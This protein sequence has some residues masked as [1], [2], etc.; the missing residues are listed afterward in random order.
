MQNALT[1]LSVE[2]HVSL[3][4]IVEGVLELAARNQLDDLE[5]YLLRH[6]RSVSEKSVWNAEG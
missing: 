5:K 2:K 6:G 3:V 4:E 1:Y